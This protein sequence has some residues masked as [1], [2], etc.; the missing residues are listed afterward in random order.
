MDDIAEYR[1]SQHAEQVISGILIGYRLVVSG[2][3]E[4]AMVPWHRDP[5]LPRY[6]V[7]VVAG[8]ESVVIAARDWAGR[9][10]DLEAYV[11]AW[12]LERVQ[13]A[14]T[15]RGHGRRRDPWWARV[16]RRANPGR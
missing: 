1:A 14:G 13:L 15:R 2:G 16:W 10:E 6:T 3:T 7:R 9:G 11:R 12:L 8:D 5:S 4:V